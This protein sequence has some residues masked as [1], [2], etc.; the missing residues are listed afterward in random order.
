MLHL[1]KILKFAMVSFVFL[2]MVATVFFGMQWFSNSLEDMLRRSGNF[3]PGSLETSVDNAQARA[4]QPIPKLQTLSPQRNWD[5]PDAN[6]TAQAALSVEM[7][8]G[9]QKILFQKNEQKRMPVA[10]LTKLMTALVVMENYDLD[11]KI[12][13]SANAMAQEGEQGV[14]KLGQEFSAKSLLYTTLMESNNRSAYAL[15]EFM[16]VDTFIGLMNDN[17]KQL[18]L[19]DTHFHDATGLDAR[20]YSTAKD[21]A[22]LSGYLFENYPLFKEIISLKEY[23]VSMYGGAFHHRAINTNELLGQNNIIGGKTGFTPEAQ[24]CFMVIQASSAKGNYI[25]SIVL[26]SQDR[27]AEMRNIIDWVLEAYAW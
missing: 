3:L 22:R 10:S 18:G 21:I 14:L 12:T 26:G 23:D 25:I 16:G 5:E 17:A 20:S 7:G 4:N 27:F 8:G 13:I 15:S 1:Q 9:V 6:I 11:Q 19:D 2:V 24:G